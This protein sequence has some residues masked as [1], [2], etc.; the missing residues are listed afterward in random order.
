MRLKREIPLHVGV[1]STG[2]YDPKGYGFSAISILADLAILVINRVW[3]LFSNL[4]M[5]MFL[6]A[7]LSSLSKRKPSQ[8]MFTVI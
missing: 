7:T 1:G 4:H 3:F 6:R 2:M 5:G 8:I